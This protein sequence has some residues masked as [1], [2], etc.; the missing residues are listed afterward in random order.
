MKIIKSVPVRERDTMIYLNE[1]REWKVRCAMYN[2]DKRAEELYQKY[3]STYD[4]GS[5][6]MHYYTGKFAL[7]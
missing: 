6:V 2:G 1:K 5:T 3:T 4:D 7:A